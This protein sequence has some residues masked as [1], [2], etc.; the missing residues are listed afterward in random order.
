[1]IRLVVVNF[2]FVGEV[3]NIRGEHIDDDPVALA[4]GVTVVASGFTAIV[5][6]FPGTFIVGILMFA[7]RGKLV[8]HDVDK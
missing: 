5:G 4:T 8:T 6:W 2:A 7:T 3:A 1:M